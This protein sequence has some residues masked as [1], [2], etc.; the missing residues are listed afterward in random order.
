MA[1][2]LAHLVWLLQAVS[3]QEDPAVTV[4]LLALGRRPQLSCSCLG[5][6]L[7][8]PARVPAALRHPPSPRPHLIPPNPKKA[9]TYHL[10][11]T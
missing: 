9:Q 8:L 3:V 10:K 6:L 11:A 7:L 5:Q 4:Q 2:T 1:L